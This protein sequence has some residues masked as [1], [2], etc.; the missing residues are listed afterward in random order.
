MPERPTAR[1]AILDAFVEVVVEQGER[2]ATLQAVAEHAGV[3]K[4]GLLYHFGSREA[5]VEGLAER[6]DALGAEDAEALRGEADPVARFIRGSIVRETAIDRAFVA[7]FRLIQSE[8]HPSLRQALQRVD[9]GYRGVLA[10]AIG[11]DLAPV[12]ALMSDGIYLR[13]GLDPA[14]APSADD[15]ERIIAAVDDIVRRA[16]D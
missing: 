3:S 5:L 4:G 2:A 12:V 14:W 15:V 7:A 9:D 10:D 11:D 6:L 16:R 13:S 8:Q 1:E